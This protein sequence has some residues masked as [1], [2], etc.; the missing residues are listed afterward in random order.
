LTQPYWP[1]WVALAVMAVAAFINVRHGLRLPNRL[2]YPFAAAGLLLGLLHTVGVE[3]DGGSGGIGGALLCLAVGFVLVLPAYTTGWLGAGSVK[4]QM[5]WSAWLGAF[6]GA[7]MGFD[8]SLWSV[9]F[10]AL[11]SALAVALLRIRHSTKGERRLYPTGP[12]QFVGALASIVGHE[13]L[14]T[15]P[16][17]AV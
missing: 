6:Y 5:G 16:V 14:G 12:A 9:V 7:A 3:P 2:T 10:A 4:L 8:L 13:V 17:F 1:I 11:A 15:L